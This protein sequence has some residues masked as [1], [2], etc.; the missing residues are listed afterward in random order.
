[1]TRQP[2]DRARPGGAAEG[3]PPGATA[4]PDGPDPGVR[5]VGPAPVWTSAGTRI[6]RVRSGDAILGIGPPIPVADAVGVI[7]QLQDFAA[8]RLWRGDRLVFQGGHAAGDV[9]IT[10]LGDEWRC[11]HDAP[12]DNVRF[13][14]PVPELNELAREIGQAPVE[15]LRAP[16]DDRDPVLVGLAQALVAALG[17]AHAASPLFV[18]QLLLAFQTHLLQTYGGGATPAPRPGTLSPAQVRRAQACLSSHPLQRLSIAEVARAC[19]LSRS[20]FSRAFK[21]TTGQ[22]PHQWVLQYRLAQ[23]VSLLRTDRP[24]AEIAIGCGFADQSHLTR[25]FRRWMGISPAAWRRSHG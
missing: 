21:A 1:M 4:R 7:V 24:I 23:V 16:E 19:D 12:F 20:H 11:A 8:H 17:P 6:A 13:V 3:P 10:H 14:L 25:A 15:R 5:P 22:T 9:A 18:E 2:V